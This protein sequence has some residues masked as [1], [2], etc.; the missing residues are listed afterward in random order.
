MREPRQLLL[1]TR[2]FAKEKRLTSWWVLLS[3][4][5]LWAA[6]TVVCCMDSLGWPIRLVASVFSGLTL[7]RVF[8]VYHD[9]A[10]QT[11][12]KGSKVAQ[13]IMTVYGMLSLNPPTIWT[14]SHNH[15]HKNNAKIFGAQIGSFP[16]MTTGAWERA[17]SKQRLAYVVIRHPITIALGYVTIFMYGMTIR[18]LT[19]N[20]REHWDSA[21]ALVVH[22]G[23]LLTLTWFGGY[24]ALLFAMIIPFTIGSAAGAY[25]FYAQHNYPDMKIRDRADWDYVFAALHSS[26]YLPMNP[27]MQWFTGNIGF[28]HVHHLNH[29]IPFYRLPETMAYFPE[30]Q[31]PGKTTLWPWDVYR[32]CM[33]K[34]WDV[35]QDKLITFAEYNASKEAPAVP[36]AE[37]TTDDVIN[38]RDIERMQAEDEEAKAKAE[39]KEVPASAP[40]STV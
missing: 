25:L 21:L 38:T 13:A 5:A 29:K 33:L 37:P 30:L 36:D 40:K 12:L 4:L 34:L 23:C 11:I 3:G 2:E 35:K 39:G 8:I 22:F 19:Q 26:S 32:C 15:H 9:Y 24:D 31:S 6:L 20:P 28:H 7:V 1:D 27:V 14:R 10:H 17:N 18:S 16:V